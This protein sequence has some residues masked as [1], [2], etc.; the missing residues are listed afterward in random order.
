[1]SM[2][3]KR[4]SFAHQKSTEY[5]ILRVN[6]MPLNIPI[7]S[8]VTLSIYFKRKAQTCDN[9]DK[10]CH[11]STYFGLWCICQ[12]HVYVLKMSKLALSSG[13]HISSIVALAGASN[14]CLF[15]VNA[16]EIFA[17]IV[18]FSQTKQFSWSIS[19]DAKIVRLLYEMLTPFKANKI[20]KI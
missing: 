19:G 5:E 16:N 3:K 6:K 1:M 11:C 12:W 20:N 14:S 17:N 9:F 8:L 7:V 18:L 2:K 15:L 10:M 13:E 4:I